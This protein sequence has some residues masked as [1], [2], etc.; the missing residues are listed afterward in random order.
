MKLINVRKGQFVYYENNLHKVYSIKPFFKQ[1]VHIARLSDLEQKLVMSKEITYYRPKHL[2]SFIC[3]HKRYTLH[4]DKRAKVGDYILVI[5]P[6]PDSLDHHHLHAIELVSSVE[7]NGVISNKSNGIKHIEYWVMVPGLLEGA[8]VI[9]KQTPDP[10]ENPD[11]ELE[12]PD[13]LHPVLAAPRIGDVY[14]KN[15]SDPVFQAMVVAVQGRTIYLGG[16]M[17][18]Q[19]EEL[20]DSDKWS[21]VLNALDQ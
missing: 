12:D 17:T 9:D 1:S 21:Y 8:N 6:K 20:T 14:Q 2:D 11:A 18:V 16:N 7:E 15:D 10:N 19:S 4:K 13:T 3:N 5:D